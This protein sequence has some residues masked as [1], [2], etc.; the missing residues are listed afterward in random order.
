MVFDHAF[1]KA[2]NFVFLTV[3]RLLIESLVLSLF[4]QNST[5]RAKKRLLLRV[6]NELAQ[7]VSRGGTLIDS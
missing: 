5:V 6:R 1:H 2:K 3:R 7:Q 4:S